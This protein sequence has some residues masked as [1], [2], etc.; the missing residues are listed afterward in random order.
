[1][2]TPYDYEESPQGLV[3]LKN[4]R[5]INYDFLKCVISDFLEKKGRIRILE[6]GAGGAR[7]LK[8]LHEMFGKRLELFGTD[9]SKTAISYARSL[10]IGRFEISPSEIIPFKA[11]FDLILIIDLLEHLESEK[12]AKM[13]L[14]NALKKLNKNGRIYISAPIELNKFSL[15]WFFS[16][17]SPAKKLTN[18]IFGHTVQFTPQ[19]LHKLIDKK[20]TKI[21]KEF[22][23]VRIIS[24]L[25][26]LLFLYIPKILLETIFGKK[27]A[28]ALRDSN[29]IIDNS[30]YRTL[31]WI[32]KII[33]WLSRP[34]AYLGYY[35]S[36]WRR[37]SKFAAGN[38]HL[39]IERR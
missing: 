20:L 17:I 34:F 8:A 28:M 36:Y 15:T 9:I 27:Q 31:I 35:E 33:I 4:E 5:N 21:I 3:S 23:S 2:M 6:I 10:K 16:K 26:V 30:D 37:N 11:K 39:L 22:Y 18:K 13:T 25:Q 38:I 29:E 1:M 24:Q 19:V 7:N 32:K 14:D 12:T